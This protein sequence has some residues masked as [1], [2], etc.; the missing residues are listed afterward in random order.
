MAIGGSM[1]LTTQAVA[2][3]SDARHS[4]DLATLALLSEADPSSVAIAG[5]SAVNPH[6][7]EDSLTKDNVILD[8]LI[9]DGSACIGFDCVNGESFSFDTIRLTAVAVNRKEMHVSPR[10]I[11]IAFIARQGEVIEVGGSVRR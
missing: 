4:F 1:T 3:L 8:D 9:V 7:L 6:A 5:G 11:I 2:M 10:D